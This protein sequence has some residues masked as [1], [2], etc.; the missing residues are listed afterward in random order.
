MSNLTD[1]LIAAKLV[2][3]S[4]GSGGG[5][6]S[7]SSPLEVAISTR[8]GGSYSCDKTYAEILEAFDANTPI[9]A[10]VFTGTYVL[11]KVHFYAY[12]ASRIR[13]FYFEY[14]ATGLSVTQIILNSSDE[15]TATTMIASGT[16]QDI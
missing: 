14:H 9:D 2:G 16:W 7:A 6:G 4:G 1:A 3:G 10:T 11:S 12:S 8:K 15:I 5:S 13:F